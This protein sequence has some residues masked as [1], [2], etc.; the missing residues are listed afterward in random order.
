[1]QNT[2]CRA[3]VWCIE[4]ECVAGDGASARTSAGERGIGCRRD[5]LAVVA[6]GRLRG[7]QPVRRAQDDAGRD[8]RGAAVAPALDEP[9]DDTLSPGPLPTRSDALL[10]DGNNADAA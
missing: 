1:M 6:R 4:R 2:T 5:A 7:S 3:L 10:I 9:R 8:N